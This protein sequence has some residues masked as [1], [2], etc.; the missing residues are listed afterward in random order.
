MPGT[1]AAWRSG[2]SKGLGMRSDNSVHDIWHVSPPCLPIH[3]TEVVTP[4]H[5]VNVSSVKMVARCLTQSGCSN[6]DG[7]LARHP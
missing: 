3:Q 6:Q 2:R 1:L 4:T 5:I 7:F